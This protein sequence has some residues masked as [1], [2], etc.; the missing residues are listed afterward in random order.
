M[1]STPHFSRRVSLR[2]RFR[3][4]V[5]EN[6]F[7]CYVIG[8]QF[9]VILILI[10]TSASLGQS[11]VSTTAT[12]TS[13]SKKMALSSADGTTTRNGTASAFSL[14]VH[15]KFQKE[16]YLQQFLTDIA[17]L[18][19]HVKEHEKDT[20]AYEVLLSDT[21]PLSVLILERYTDKENAFER[22]HRN[23]QPFLEFRPKLAAMT[24]A[25]K[26]SLQGNSYF[27]AGVGFGD[28]VGE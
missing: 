7:L 10:I 3:R 11:N 9:A 5:H 1:Q 13:T 19:A 8:A 16:E 26:C 22:L 17:P 27:D 4:Y 21:D 12:A 28:R 24:D 2:T 20:I 25:R 15:L 18:A 6:K 23:S 14:L